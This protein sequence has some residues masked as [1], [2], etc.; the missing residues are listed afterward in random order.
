MQPEVIC[1]IVMMK[2]PGRYEES[3]L[4]G[5]AACESLLCQQKPK[6]RTFW[7]GSIYAEPK[8]QSKI[9]QYYRE[10]FKASAPGQSY[11]WRYHAGTVNTFSVIKTGLSVQLTQRDKF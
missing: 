7:G 6:E 2:P 3:T 11:W 5:Q 4:I 8:K 9:L 10:H 1:E